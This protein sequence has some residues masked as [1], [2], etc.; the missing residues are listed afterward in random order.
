[1]LYT[2][3]MDKAEENR[4]ISCNKNFKL[5]LCKAKCKIVNYGKSTNPVLLIQS[6]AVSRISTTRQRGDIAY[7]F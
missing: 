1:M 2:K 4:V 6:A 7:L 5:L 3:N